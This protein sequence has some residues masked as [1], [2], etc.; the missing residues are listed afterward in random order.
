MWNCVGCQLL[1]GWSY[2]GREIGRVCGMPVEEKCI[3]CLMGKPER[4]RMFEEVNY[5]WQEKKKGDLKGTGW[6]II[7]W[8]NL[9]QDMD[10]WQALV[11]I[12]TNLQIPQ[13]AENFLPSWE[14][15]ICQS[16]TLP[17]RVSCLYGIWHSAISNYN[18]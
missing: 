5:R 15:I 6:K 2:W 3:K 13:Y 7:Y 10:Q 14:I 12:V 8:I 18:E 1:L 16:R 4:K 17:N 9:D 11:K